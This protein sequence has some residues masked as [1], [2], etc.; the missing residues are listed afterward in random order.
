MIYRYCA[1]LKQG[2]KHN[3]LIQNGMW[4][5]STLTQNTDFIHLNS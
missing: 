3:S 2:G 1:C 4:N 5:M